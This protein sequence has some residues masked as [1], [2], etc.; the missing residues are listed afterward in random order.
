MEQFIAERR[1]E[2][3]RLCRQNGVLRLDLVSS[4]AASRG[5]SPDSGLGFLAEFDPE[6][7]V[8]RADAYFAVLFGLQDLF[9]RPV[10]LV[11]RSAIDNPYFLRS[12]EQSMEP[13][14]AA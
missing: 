10:D 4:A 8:G 9:G 5:F 11:M 13:L 6:L 7:R 1:P 12:L 2:V 14:Y 3:E